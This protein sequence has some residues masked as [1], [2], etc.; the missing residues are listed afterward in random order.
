M[1]RLAEVLTLAAAAIAAYL[2]LIRQPTD[3]RLVAILTNAIGDEAIISLNACDLF[4]SVDQ[5]GSEGEPVAISRVVMRADLKS[6]NFGTIRMVPNNQQVTLR[7][8]RKPVTEAMLNQFDDIRAVSSEDNRSS[9]PDRDGARDLLNND[10]FTLYVRVMAE[11]ITID[12]Q[13]TLVAHEDAPNFFEFAQAVERLPSPASYRI[14]TAYAPG[15]PSADTLLTGEVVAI[16][17]IEF[18]LPTEQKAKDLA[19]AFHNQAA[20]HGCDQ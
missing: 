6:Y 11:V 3:E 13:Q 16:P 12:G 5:V 1:K 15:G 7:I 14:T 9:W 8:S 20:A 2:F 10:R 17:T 18:R 4:V 19:H